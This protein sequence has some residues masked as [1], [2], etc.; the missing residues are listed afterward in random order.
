MSTDL[1]LQEQLRG[2]SLSLA[3]FRSASAS[4]SFCSRTAVAFR[5]LCCA[6]DRVKNPTKIE[7]A[8]NMNRRA[9]HPVAVGAISISR[10]VKRKCSIMAPETEAHAT[11][12]INP[13]IHAL[14]ITA[15]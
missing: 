14:K 7:P 4:A 10:V 15:G 6:A 2:K 5:S 9:I 8:R 3:A 11:A 12:P 1:I 13:Q